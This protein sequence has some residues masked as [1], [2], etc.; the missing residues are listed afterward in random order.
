VTT[1]GAEGL[2]V[3]SGRHRW[4][5]GWELQD[6]D[7]TTPTP[8]QVVER[9]RASAGLPH[10]DVELQGAFEWTF[11]AELAARFRSGPVFL[12]GDAATRTSPRRATGMNTGI[13][14]AHNLAWKLAWVL[15][16]WADEALLDTY[17][18]ERRPVGLANAQRS[19]LQREDP[20][21]ASG[22]ED[23]GVTYSSAAIATMDHV[24][25]PA[26]IGE[27]AAP[28]RRAPHGWL[29][30]TGRRVSTLDLFDGR[31]T[32]LTGSGGSDWCAAAQ[33]LA[34]DDLPLAV[35]RLGPDVPDPDGS[36]GLRYGVGARGAV[37]IRPD[38]FVAWQAPSPTGDRARLLRSAVDLATG[39]SV[40]TDVADLS[41]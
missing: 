34:V 17:E 27:R 35:L 26:T 23:F 10:L 11:G 14:A 33:R 28:G 3:A 2:F 7:P 15:R 41:A 16:G 30:L 19:L 22:L 9:I 24:E 39:R 31:L 12:V 8:E 20:H 37:L 36:L 38:G 1:P 18:E 29:D 4:G 6:G 32:L 21:E 13:A 25:P 40:A 5:Y